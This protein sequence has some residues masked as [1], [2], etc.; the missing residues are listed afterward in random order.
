M[1]ESETS[2]SSLRSAPQSGEAGSSDAVAPAVA[3]GALPD[4]DPTGAT[5]TSSALES[6]RDGYL[7]DLQRVTAE[8][9]NF[10]RQTIKRNAEIVAQAAARL[11]E[12]LLPVLDT[13]EAA[14]RQGVEG[15]ET[16]RGQLLGVLESNGLEVFDGPGEPFDPTRHEAVMTAEVGEGHPDGSDGPVV[17]EVLRT[18]YSW[19]GRVLRPAMV[20]VTGS[21]SES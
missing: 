20:K 21:G 8:F 13:C 17:V 11:A 12:A 4:Q 3:D 14:V 7:A 10:R 6:E 19:K 16:V 2:S 9:A 18:G 15:M 1:N 5:E